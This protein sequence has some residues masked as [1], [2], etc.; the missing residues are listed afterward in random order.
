MSTLLTKNNLK[1]VSVLKGMDSQQWGRLRIKSSDSALQAPTSG[2]DSLK[3]EQLRIWYQDQ[4]DK[5]ASTTPQQK[6]PFTNHSVD[7]GIIAGALIA[8]DH[9][10]TN[11]PH[12]AESPEMQEWFKS[13]IVTMQGSEVQ[14]SE[15][16]VSITKA[17]DGLFQGLR[18]G[19]DWLTTSGLASDQE[20]LTDMLRDLLHKAN[21][22]V[23]ED[24]MDSNFS[25]NLNRIIQDH[26]V[27]VIDALEA[28]IY[29][30]DVN[31]EVAVEALISAG[32]MDDRATQ[33]ARLS[34]LE[35]ALESSNVCIRDAA[36]IGIGAMD[37]PA[38]IGSLQKAIDREQCGLLLQNLM[39]TLE[40]LKGAR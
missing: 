34:M 26:G 12:L 40:Q 24:G 29:A 6:P 14:G 35:R 39:D 28:M 1:N 18:Y 4:P 11:Q 36:S 15:V 19:A 3:L 32:R 16:Q 30:E 20:M 31:Q 2:A 8:S 17:I 13:L 38:A 37:D 25:N 9:R 5:A 27:T 33:H 7:F 21:Y 10:T 22:E 23:F